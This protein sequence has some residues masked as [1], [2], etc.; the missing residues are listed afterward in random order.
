MENVDWGFCVSVA[1]SPVFSGMMPVLR[2]T[3]EDL[4][5]F[6]VA[7]G[8]ASADEVEQGDGGTVDQVDRWH[9]RGLQVGD[10]RA[11]GVAGLGL[12]VVVHGADAGL[13]DADGAAGAERV[14]GLVPGL[15]GEAADESLAE[16]TAF[17]IV[18]VL[19]GF[20][21]ARGV[22]GEDAVEALGVGFRVVQ[23]LL[24]GF[25]LGAAVV[26]VLLFVGG[27]V[28][29]F[30]LGLV[31]D[32]LCGGFHFCDFL[33]ELHQGSFLLVIGCR[34]GAGGGCRRPDAG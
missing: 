28:S 12:E 4:Q 11:D 2:V 34:G 16:V 21:E 25:G 17:E 15:V 14:G 27:E 23:N 6:E 7:F 3:L 10:G 26:E 13:V 30:V 19:F 8:A 5:V 1:S 31:D 22:A 32:G 29:A 18:L 20:A 33:L 24:E 9:A